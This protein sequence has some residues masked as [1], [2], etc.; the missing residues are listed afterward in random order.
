[1]NRRQFLLG[2]LLL[3]FALEAHATGAEAGTAAQLE[4][5]HRFI[6]KHRGGLGAF[7]HRFCDEKDQQSTT[8][9]FRETIDKHHRDARM[10]EIGFLTQVSLRQA[11]LPSGTEI[12]PIGFSASTGFVPINLAIYA[13]AKT[14]AFTHRTVLHIGLGP[15]TGGFESARVSACG[16][17]RDEVFSR[18]N[19]DALGARIIAFT[20]ENKAKFE[21]SE[22]G[23]G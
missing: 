21:F 9:T 3:P 17:F 12:S 4:A 1:M 5:I 18:Q 19:A 13:A 11:K 7:R 10:I 22:S 15:P 8:L 6:R 14:G 2:A 16:L 23:R 20:N